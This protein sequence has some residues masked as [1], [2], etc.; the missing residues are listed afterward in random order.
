MSFSQLCLNPN[1]YKAIHT[2]GYTSPTPIQTHSIPNILNGKDVVASAQTGTGKTAAFILPALHL[3]SQQPSSKKTRVLVLTPTR[4]LASQITQAAM[5]YGKFLTFKIANLVGGMPYHQQ[6]KALMRGADIIVAT[7]GRLLDHIQSKRV[8]LSHIQMLV[9]D[10]ADRMLDMG[11]IDDVQS[12]AKLTPADRQTL[13]FSATVDKNVSQ[14]VRRL[15]KNPVYIDLSK[16]KLTAPQIKQELYKANNVQH[17]T[18]L[19]KHFLNDAN[20]YKAIIFSATKLN[21]DRLATEL[22]D[23]GYAAA[24]LHGDLRQNVRNRTIEKLRR[25]KIQFLVAT[26]VAARGIDISDITHVINYDLPKFS[27]DYIHRIGRTGRA[28]KSGVAISFVLPGDFRHLQRI[29]RYIGKRLHVI[30]NV[31]MNQTPSEQSQSCHSQKH[32]TVEHVRREKAKFNKHH[33]SKKRYSA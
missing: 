16:E 33:R 32:H 11:F 17:K 30:Q 21:A 23:Q 22:R 29:E 14:V 20:I 18:K 31:G 15:L 10:E 26:D 3:L 24:A 2:C 25:G 19:L 27:E 4:E 9:L 5:T 6:I 28:G 8:D 1:I 12:I 7:P 13:L